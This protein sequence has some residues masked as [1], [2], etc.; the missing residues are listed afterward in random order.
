MAI[1][2]GGVGV[3]NTMLMSVYERTREIGVLRA[4]GWRRR[5]VLELILKEAMLMG[6]LGG[7]LGIGIAFVL[8]Y[9]LMRIPYI[10]GALQPTFDAAVFIRAFVVALLLGVIGGLY[11]AYR[12]TRLL[13]VEALRYE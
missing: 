3:L 9:G 8:T 7:V 12:A 13:P 11:P 2:V 6:I 4:L 1:F 10:A 5:G